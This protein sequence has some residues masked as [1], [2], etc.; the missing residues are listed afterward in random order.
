MNEAIRETNFPDLKLFARGKVRDIYD[1]GELFMI[2]TTDRISAYDSVF[3]DAIPDKGKVL[4]QISNFWFEKTSHVIENHIVATN[5][6]DFPQETKKY[7]DL[8]KGRSIIVKKTT[9]LTIECVVRGYL[10]G[11]AWA[12]YQESGEVCGINLPEDLL[13]KSRLPEPIFTP[14]TKAESGH[15]INISIEQAIEIVGKETAEFVR[16]KSIE[17]YQTACEL[18]KDKDV[19]ISDTKFEFG[20]I[21]DKIILIDEILTPDSSRF[22]EKDT[23]KPGKDS[24]SYDKQFVR[25]YVVSIGWDKN[26]PAPNLPEDI[27]EKT[28]TKYKAIFTIITGRELEI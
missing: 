10:D 9:P 3:P 17:I 1:L 13:K 2:V 21:G 16:S 5:V 4:T 25:D 22:W 15:D 12:G 8:L 7:A 27:I 18:I 14:A 28:S 23:Y 19:V 24:L 20:T 26:P 6:D 11:S